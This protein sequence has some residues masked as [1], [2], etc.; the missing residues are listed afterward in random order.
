[1]KKIVMKILTFIL[2][3]IFL[4][5]LYNLY[6]IF[7]EYKNNKDMYNDISN[8]VTKGDNEIDIKNEE[9]TNLKEINDDYLFWLFIP[10]TNIS[11]PVVKSKD[12]EDYLYRNFKGE[13]NIGGSIF[14]DSSNSQEDDN[15]I[16]HGHNMKDKSMFG[17]L[18]NLL[19]PEYLDKNRTIYIYLENKILEYEIFS[20][21]IVN[22]DTFP[23]KNNFSNDEDFNDYINIVMSK[24]FYKLD[25][26]E[27]GKKNILTLST[28]T[29][30]TG[31]ERTIVN[32]KLKSVENIN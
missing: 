2:G 28:C 10:D 31:D 29:N 3:L 14:V 16:I 25:Y 18:S 12:N 15:I 9:Y 5:S 6:N 19:K 1:M 21:Y 30:A 27:D 26:F 7:S 13:E 8:I 17:T 24:S 22:G 32:A 11:Y 20:S 4:Y 23:Y